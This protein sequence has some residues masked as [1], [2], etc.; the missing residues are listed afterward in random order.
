MKKTLYAELPSTRRRLDR[1]EKAY[2]EAKQ[3]T[4]R[5]SDRA[6][7]AIGD[8]LYNIPLMIHDDDMTKDEA[9]QCIMRLITDQIEHAERHAATTV[10]PIKAIKSD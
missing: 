6:F 7:S 2:R 4:T 10:N 5:V 1:L 3:Q 8:I 9:L